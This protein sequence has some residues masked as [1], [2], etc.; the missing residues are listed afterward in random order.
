VFYKK[1]EN[2]WMVLECDF[3]GNFSFSRSERSGPTLWEPF[4]FL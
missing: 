3:R 2:N 4:L 1:T